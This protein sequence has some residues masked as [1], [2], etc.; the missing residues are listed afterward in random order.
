MLLL[1]LRQT[2][3]VDSVKVTAHIASCCQLL[4]L[5]FCSEFHFCASRRGGPL[6]PEARINAELSC[7]RDARRKLKAR[8]RRQELGHEK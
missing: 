1:S 2:A 4:P 8:K 3:E 6:F 5:F 7:V